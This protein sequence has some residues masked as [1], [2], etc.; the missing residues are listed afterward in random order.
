MKKVRTREELED[1]IKVLDE[2]LNDAHELAVENVD[3]QIRLTKECEEL[4]VKVN[5]WLNVRDIIQQELV[6]QYG[7]VIT[8]K[9][10]S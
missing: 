10:G 8:N 7:V 2:L 1:G 5:I 4:I 3:K 6:E 9:V